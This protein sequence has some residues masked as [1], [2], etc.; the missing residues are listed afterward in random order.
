M[1]RRAILMGLA[2]F[3][4]AGCATRPADPEQAALPITL[5]D[6]FVGRSV[7]VGTFSVPLTGLRRKFTAKL[8]GEKGPGTLTIVEDFFYED[9]ERDRLTWRFQRSG[10][11]AWTGRRE[12]TVG[13]ALVAEDGRRV[14]LR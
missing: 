10:A 6:A 1:D 9:G 5:L 4:V 2:T 14:R 3:G 12:D 13:V 7:G 8:H 11:G